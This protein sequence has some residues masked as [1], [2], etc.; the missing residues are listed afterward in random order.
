MHFPLQNL[1]FLLKNL[2]FLIKNLHLY[3]KSGPGAEDS[4]WVP[5]AQDF[6]EA[7]RKIAESEIQ[8]GKQTF[9]Q[10]DEDSAVLVYT[11]ARLRCVKM[12]NFVLKTGNFVLKTGNL[13]FKMMDFAERLCLATRSLRRATTARG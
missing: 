12:M 11:A 1:H 8:K 4:A 2:H 6:L 9:N 7:A 5:W 3:I 13:A 10:A